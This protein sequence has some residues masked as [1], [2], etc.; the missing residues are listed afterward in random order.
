LKTN[1]IILLLILSFPLCAKSQNPHT[2]SLKNLLLNYPKEDSIR[3][4]L[5][6]QLAF[7][8]HLSHP[9]EC[10]KYSQEALGISEKIKFPKGI[11]GSRIGLNLN[12]Q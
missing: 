9:G 10:L 2:D 8:T 7:E 3:V 1:C 12:F 5:L 11:W 6:I 4:N